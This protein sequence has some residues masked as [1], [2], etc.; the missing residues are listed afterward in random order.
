MTTD[1]H[2]G[3][4]LLG[5]ALPYADGAE[6]RLL[7]VF[8]S[9]DDRSSRSDELPASIVDWPTRYHL[10]RLRSNL[11]RP[12]RLPPGAR[13]LDIGAGTGALSRY[14]G[15]AGLDVVALE[16]SLDRATA[17]AERCRDL[18]G[19]EVVCGPLAAFDDPDGFDLVVVCGVLEYAHAV[20]GGEA[21]AE[22]FLAKVRSLCRPDGT[23]VLAIENR[24]GLKYLLGY[25]EDHLGRPWIGLEGYPDDPGVRTWS[26]RELGALLAGAGFAEQR[27]LFPFPDY[28]LPT[29]VV[30]EAIYDEPDAVDLL[31]QLVANPVVDYANAPQLL[32]DD[33]AAHRSLVA[34]GLGAEVANSLVVVAGADPAG[35]AALVDDG[36]L[37]WRF[38]DERGRRWLRTTEVRAG[39]PRVVVQRREPDGDGG[40]DVEP[41]Q[42]GETSEGWLRQ[43]LVAESPYRVG[44]TL[45]QQALEAAR[46]HDLGAVGAVVAR[47]RSHLAALERPAPDGV[48]HPFLP[49]GT[50]TV[51]PPDHLDVAFDNF[52]DVGDDGLAF[53]DP[54]WVVD[55]G[56]ATTMVV[57]RSL[58]GLARRFVT[59]G[60]EHPW[61]PEL[62]IDQLTAVLGAMCGEAVTEVRLAGWRRAEAELQHLVRGE[63]PQRV[64]DEH[65]ELGR[66]CRASLPVA[67]TLPLTRLRGE[68]AALVG[69]DPVEPHRTLAE[70]VRSLRDVADS[71]QALV[72]ELSDVVAELRQDVHRVVLHGRRLEGEL[73]ALGER[74]A[75]AEAEI[76]HLRG[77]VK[78]VSDDREAI[79]SDRD[80]LVRHN[81]EL[82]A[83]LEHIQ[84]QLA[85]RVYAKAADTAGK[86][87]KR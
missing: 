13:V 72:V 36:V 40:I 47:W 33:R 9:A 6:D 21:S 76:D 27:W 26:R 45:Q 29:T 85:Y 7:E 77:I 4:R 38:G 52:V 12:L 65:A 70:T 79:R 68:L 56:V 86:L 10:S 74:H 44:E 57:D 50:A 14:L 35:P 80:A 15:E 84:R 34:A 69:A 8:R 24:M 87:R 61:S 55:G 43:Q 20:I 17:A 16:G 59:T 75:A 41:G 71:R 73:D 64:A 58:W 1:P 11:L 66:L 2:R 53:I 18:A 63:D 62:S 3:V 28:K 19:V 5:E 22:A 39:T 51:L 54:E 82:R 49:E 81:A 31:D 83:R 32:T 60:V 23:L 46:R 25:A 48:T 30:T 67:R 78:E 42:R 37:A